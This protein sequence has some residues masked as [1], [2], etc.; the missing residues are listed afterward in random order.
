M[1]ELLK[2]IQEDVKYLTELQPGMPWR[3]H[4][5]FAAQSFQARI[6]QVENYILYGITPTAQ[7]RCIQGRDGHSCIYDAMN[8]VMIDYNYKPHDDFS[9][10]KFSELEVKQILHEMINESKLLPDQI[11]Y[12]S[13]TERPEETFSEFTLIGL[14]RGG[15]LKIKVT[16]D[17]FLCEKLS[18]LINR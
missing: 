10:L 13:S 11:T 9:R 12:Q 5:E 17:V 2:K 15:C 1:L 16:G 7:R 6:K 14:R 18:P 3:E 8:C 4:D